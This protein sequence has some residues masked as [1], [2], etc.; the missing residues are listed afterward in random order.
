MG[1]IPDLAKCYK[2]KA[3]GKASE[4]KQLVRVVTLIED[5]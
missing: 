2:V 5:Q 4:M 1:N 3:L